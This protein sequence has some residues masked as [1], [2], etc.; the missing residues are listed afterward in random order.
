MELF[1]TY[2]SA[3]KDPATAL[4]PAAERYISDRIAGVHTRAISIN[5]LFAILSGRFGLIGPDEPIPDYDHLLKPDEIPAMAE[6]VAA[7]LKQWEV[8]RVRWFTVA[9]E[10]DPNVSR[11]SDVMTR[12]ATL[13]GSEFELELWE[14]TGMLGL[15]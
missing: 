13:A 5:T 10:M 1:A 7:T 2:C 15:V 12:A 8:T 9:F 11:Y 3:N 14:P 4:L 6:R